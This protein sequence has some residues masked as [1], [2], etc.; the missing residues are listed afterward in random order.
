MPAKPLRILY[1][2]QGTGNG[3][4]SRARD[5]VPLLQ[6]RAQVDV[7]IS[8]IQTDLILP[9]PVRYK[10]YGLS[11]I[12]GKHGGVDLW[13]TAKRARIMNLWREIKSLPIQDYDL[14]VSDFEP[15]S[16][17]ACKLAG[18]PCVSL[19]HQAGVMDA[20]A[21]KPAKDDLMG[22]MIMHNYAPFTDAYGFHFNRYGARVFT[23]VIRADIRQL[24]PTQE[25][26]YTVYLPA[27]SDEALVRYLSQWPEVQWQVFSKHNMQ[28]RTEGNVVLKPVQNEAFVASMAS[29]T[30]VLCGAGFETPAEALFLGKKVLVIPMANQYEQY[31]NAAG[32]AQLGVPVV[33]KLDQEAK[34]TIDQW[35]KTGKPVAVEWPDITAEVIDY[36][37]YNAG[38]GAQALPSGLSFENW[39][40]Q[41]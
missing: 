39:L 29:S 31:C 24:Q 13:A 37:L 36:M 3:H 12:F 30:G 5:V 33:W 22:R 27:Y 15:V 34:P 26:H 11:F 17:W 28:P 18:K 40:A 10:F 41:R 16:S 1:A 32:A 8:G 23:P 6:E 38:F 19:S 35:I 25:G 21:P 9:Y 4:V 7:L 2:I 20:N 14:V